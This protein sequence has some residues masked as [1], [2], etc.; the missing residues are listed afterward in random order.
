VAYALEPDEPLGEAARRLV[1]EQLDSAMTS[2][3]GGEEGRAE[4]V[5]DARKRLKRAR[6]V[7]RVARGVLGDELYRRDNHALRDAGRRLSEVRDA[8]VLVASL[9]SL[10]GSLPEGLRKKLHDAFVERRAAA[11]RRSFVDDDE[12]GRVCRDLDGARDR[13]VDWPDGE[14][15]WHA[16]GDGLERIYRDGR[17]AMT[18]AYADPSAEHFH[19]WRKRAKDLWH[20]LVLL[21]PVWPE[22]V[23]PSAREAHALAD[24]LG[25]DHDL[26]ALRQ[27][28]SATSAEGLLTPGQR[29]RVHDAITARSDEL[30]LR[31]EPLG[32]RLYAERASAYRERLRGWWRAWRNGSRAVDA[33]G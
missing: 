17:R 8:E 27:A 16:L 21:K 9:A 22:L 13:V 14:P 24:L 28:L 23:E 25:D 19:E 29:A 33:D 30:R 15:G 1:S 10:S 5:H 7:L 12:L 3:R 26:E 20:T 4:A 31:A 18:R 11:T 2:L 6:T 32:R